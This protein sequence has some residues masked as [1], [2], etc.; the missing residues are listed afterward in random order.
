MKNR[1]V[2]PFSAMVGQSKLK[3]ALLINVVNPLVGGVLIGGEK[4]TGKSTLVR[5]L[6]NL[7]HDMK[8]VE[9]PLNVT[10]DRF[11]GAIDIEKAIAEGKKVVNDSILMEADGNILYVD[12]VNLLSENI[13]NALLEVSQSG[14]NRLER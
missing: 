11:V 6:G 9:L 14:I 7:I 5:G 2:Y 10:E 1:Y 13:V 3:K 12:E 4:G 8:V